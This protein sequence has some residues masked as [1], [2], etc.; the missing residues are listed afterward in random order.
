MLRR[1]VQK[2]TRAVARGRAGRRIVRLKGISKRRGPARRTPR[3]GSE[4]VLLIVKMPGRESPRP[5]LVRTYSAGSKPRSARATFS[6][7]T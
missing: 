2:S 3:D 6:E 4:T 7:S 1:A 5:L